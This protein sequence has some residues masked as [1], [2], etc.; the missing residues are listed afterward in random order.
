MRLPQHWQ[1]S[2]CKGHWP[3]LGAGWSGKYREDGEE[4]LGLSL[5]SLPKEDSLDVHQPATGLYRAW[6][7]LWHA[8]ALAEG[9][10]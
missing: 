4:K 1:Q 5:L 7:K 9:G 2:L 3:W 8:V 10:I 6:Q